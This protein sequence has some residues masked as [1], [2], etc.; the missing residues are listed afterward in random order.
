[1]NYPIVICSHGRPDRIQAQTLAFLKR[2]E[3]P[4]EQI[5]IY[6][7]D[8]DQCAVYKKAIR[9][10]YRFEIG[11]PTLR[12]KRNHILLTREEG[13][14]FVNCDDDLKNIIVHNDGATMQDKRKDQ[15]HWITPQE[16]SLM[17]V[18]GFHECRT[19]GANLWGVAPTNN[20]AFCRDKVEVGLKFIAGVFYGFKLR[21][22]SV[23]LTHGSAKEE[24]ERSL[25]H[26]RRDGCVVRLAKYG[27]DTVYFSNVGGSAAD[28][29]DSRLRLLALEIELLMREFPGLCTPFERTC[30]GKKYPDIKLANLPNML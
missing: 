11:G 19:H 8:R 12:E 26:F 16:F 13:H 9:G 10:G 23:L 5:S 1:M 2:M 18:Q 24:F 29:E 22:E 20:P 14:Y 28:G 30:G 27:V 7:S 6:T 17:C 3:I 25:R 15:G 4:D 21:R